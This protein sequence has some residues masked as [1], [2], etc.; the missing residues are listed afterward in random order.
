MYLQ[1]HL[2][3]ARS[4]TEID[5]ITAQTET[6]CIHQKNASYEKFI[7]LMRIKQVQESIKEYA[8][9]TQL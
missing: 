1:L 4:C 9:D 3:V 8:T 6:Y 5:R 2:D 7:F